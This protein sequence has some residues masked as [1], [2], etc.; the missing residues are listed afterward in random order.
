MKKSVVLILGSLIAVLVLCALA[1]G[2]SSPKRRTPALTND[3]LGAVGREVVSAPVENE[4]PSE[5]RTE[6]QSTRGSVQWQR[7]LRRAVQVARSESKLIVVAVDTNWCGWC[8]RMD[9]TI[10]SDPAIIALSRQHV[11]VKANAEDQAEGQRFA[12]QMGVTGY[13][14]TIVL[15]DQGRVLNIAKGYI[16]STSA[17]VEF[18]QQAQTTRRR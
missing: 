18:V 10:Y 4:S 5:R 2:Q 17:F 6:T 12:E 7:D 16:A 14:T 8:K 1:G 15:D 9:K 13:P 11:F 3:D